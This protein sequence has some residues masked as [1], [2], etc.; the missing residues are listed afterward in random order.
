M[1]NYELFNFKNISNN[2]V[3]ILRPMDEYK[4]NINY[5]YNGLD[6][7]KPIEDIP[8]KL[9]RDEFMEQDIEID[10]SSNKFRE[11]WDEYKN[12]YN[13]NNNYYSSSNLENDEVIKTENLKEDKLNNYDDDLTS[14]YI[15]AKELDD[16]L[17]A[18]KEEK[19][20]LNEK[21]ELLDLS[22]KELEQE[23]ELLNIEK[24]KFEEYKTFENDKL[25]KDKI[26]F[27]NLVE[28]MK[29]KIET[30]LK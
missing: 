13:E 20:E 3:N 10:I 28:E 29:N 12:K 22:K 27:Q 4:K 21:K 14:F 18:L 24:E 23:K 8:D 25:S 16:Y 9:Y 11:V 5:L 2:D 6:G 15:K 19:K 26:N 1:N 17:M 30:I 7:A